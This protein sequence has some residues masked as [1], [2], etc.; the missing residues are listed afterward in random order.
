[1]DYMQNSNSPNLSSYLPECVYVH[2]PVTSCIY[3][4]TDNLTYI[5]IVDMTTTTKKKKFLVREA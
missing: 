1:M 4:H 2:G 5:Y 3:A